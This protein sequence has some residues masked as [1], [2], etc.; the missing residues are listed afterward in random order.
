V[1]Y[2]LLSEPTTHGGQAALRAVE[3]AGQEVA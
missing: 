3:P 1:L 2:D